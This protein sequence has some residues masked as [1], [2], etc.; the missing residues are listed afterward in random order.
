M[1]LEIGMLQ[2][3]AFPSDEA[4]SDGSALGEGFTRCGDSCQGCRRVLYKCWMAHPQD[5]C[6]VGKH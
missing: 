5:K 1:A 4:G 2:A 6:Q 3:T